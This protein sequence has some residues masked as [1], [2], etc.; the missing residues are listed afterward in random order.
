M[1]SKNRKSW[2][3]LNFRNRKDRSELL[4]SRKLDEEYLINEYV[5]FII[6]TD[7]SKVHS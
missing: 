4:F 7:E 6:K 3:K 5:L 2:K 1:L